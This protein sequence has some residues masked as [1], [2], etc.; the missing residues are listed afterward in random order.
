M[1]EVTGLGR[2]I[3]FTSEEGSV[4]QGNSASD[5]HIHNELFQAAIGLCDEIEKLI[6]KFWWGQRGDRRKIHWVK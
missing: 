2:K 3:T 5:P 1:E 6:R 4:D